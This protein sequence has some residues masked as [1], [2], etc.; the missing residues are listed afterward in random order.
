M[1]RGSRKRSS[2]AG[3]E[4]MERVGGRY[5]KMEG[6]CSTG[7]SPQWAVVPME[8]GRRKCNHSNHRYVC[9]M[10]LV[11]LFKDTESTSYDTDLKDTMM[12]GTRIRNGVK[13]KMPCSVLWHC[14]CCE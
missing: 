5:E 8:E 1:E 13:K 14:V 7:Q 6:H 2:S 12:T 10:S 9:S 4:K 3:S 11:G